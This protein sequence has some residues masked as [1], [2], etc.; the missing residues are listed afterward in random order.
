M[1]LRTIHLY[2]ALGDEYGRE[3]RLAVKS[4]REAVRALCA[5]YRGFRDRFK[6]GFYHVVRG[7]DL[8][9]GFGLD[10]QT[11]DMRLGKG[12]LHIVPV[13]EGQGGRGGAFAKIAIGLAI[14]AGGF[15][16]APAIA[17][18]GATAL[19][20]GGT[21]LL[22]YGNIVAIGAAV[23]L[24]GV[25]QLLSPTPKPRVGREPTDKRESFLFN[26]PENVVTQGGAVPLVYGR[27]RVGSVL[28]SAGL[29]AEQI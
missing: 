9:T 5:L 29:T 4:P 23:A 2:G 27:A 16:F 24:T 7:R 12:D 8:D 19:S 10:E 14:V 20:I 22:T 17:G 25:A 6:P 18:L 21:S 15:F 1:M 13:V 28:I 26:G 3:H 11:I